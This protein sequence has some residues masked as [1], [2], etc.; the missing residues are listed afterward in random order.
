[1]YSLHLTCQIYY[2]YATTPPD[3]T[4]DN[5]LLAYMCFH[6]TEQLFTIHQINYLYSVIWSSV[7]STLPYSGHILF[8]G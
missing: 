1:M 4:V 3:H 8:P 5:N 2:Y 7:P 6:Q